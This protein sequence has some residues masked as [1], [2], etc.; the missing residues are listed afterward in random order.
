MFVKNECLFYLLYIFTLLYYNFKNTPLLF[1][2]CG[3]LCC[4]WAVS[5][6]IKGMWACCSGFCIVGRGC[7]M[8]CISDAKDSLGLVPLL[9]LRC[10]DESGA[11]VLWIARQI[12]NH[13]EA[14]VILLLVMSQFIS[15]KLWYTCVQ[16]LK[17]YCDKI[18]S[19]GP[20]TCH[21]KSPSET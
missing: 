13:W 21:W 7:M 2:L 20:K 8:A 19:L 5:S 14:L 12:I 6:H 11:C 1:K 18:S 17:L 10:W 16:S 4:S 9:V 15:L 3:S